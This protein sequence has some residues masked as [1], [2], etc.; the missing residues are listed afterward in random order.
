MGIASF[1]PGELEKQYSEAKLARIALKVA[2]EKLSYAVEADVAIAG[3]GPAGLTLAWLLA[4]QG[5]RVTLV[6]HR[7]STGGGMKGGSMLFPVALVEEGLAAVILEKAG[8]RLHRVGEGL[9]AMDPVE[10][11]AKLTARAVD[12]GAVILPG[13]HV[14]DLIVRGSGSNVRVAGIV[15]NWAPVV[16]AGWHVDPL[17]IEARAVVDATGHDAQLARL[18]ERRLPGSLKVPGMSSLD[19]WT[20]ERQVVEH[21]GEIFPGLYAAGMSVAEVYNLRRM[22]PV[23]GGMIASAARLAEMLAERLAG[24][25]MGLATGVARSG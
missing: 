2:L 22:G 25:R 24:K 8:V 14:E 13:L 19:V 3:A 15:V 5:L 11:V 6:E 23:F 17:Y 20:G 18:L 1:Y 7:L 4:E 9:Y 10:A 16:E 21:T 12:A